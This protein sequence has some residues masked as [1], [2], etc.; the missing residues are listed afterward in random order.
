MPPIVAR[1]PLAVVTLAATQHR[2]PPPLGFWICHQPPP[3]LLPRICA[4]LPTA[5]PLPMG[6]YSCPG[7]K[8]QLTALSFGVTIGTEG[9]GVG[10][11]VGVSLGTGTGVSVARS[12]GCVS[13]A[14]TC[15]V[16][17]WP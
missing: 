8:R 6:T 11:M 3:E 4:L 7:P 12:A 5:S 16:P 13:V 10:V 15:V 14:V 17:G 1:S 9:V 2:S